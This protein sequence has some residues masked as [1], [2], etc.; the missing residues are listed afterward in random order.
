MLRAAIVALAVLAAFPAA[1]ASL[2]ELRAALVGLRQPLAASRGVLEATP[3]IRGA[4]AELSVAKHLLRDWLEQHLAGLPEDGDVVGF[5]RQ[6][7]DELRQANLFCDGQDKCPE[8][9]GFSAYGW[10][11]EMR[12]TTQDYGRFLLVRTALGIYCGYDDSAYAY[13]WSDGHWRRFWEH[14]QTDY[15]GAAYKPQLIY[16]V[17]VVRPPGNPSRSGAATHVSP[18][19]MGAAIPLHD[20]RSR[21]PTVSGMH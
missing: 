3:N 2:E 14:E 17:Q 8:D 21:A 10:L 1:G 16:Q 5:G 15:D 11:G 12:F 13:E 9:G 18:D 7:N 4:T 20:D 19:P 6:L